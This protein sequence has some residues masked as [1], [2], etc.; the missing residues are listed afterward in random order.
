MVSYQPWSPLGWEGATRCQGPCP[1]CRASCTPPSSPCCWRWTTLHCWSIQ[2]QPPSPGIPALA[3]VKDPPHQPLEARWWPSWCA[4]AA[5]SRCRWVGGSRRGRRCARL[6]LKP[7]SIIFSS[8]FYNFTAKDNNWSM[9]LH[10]NPAA[11]RKAAGK[12]SKLE[13]ASMACRRKQSSW[14][15]NKGKG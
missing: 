7:A 14:R 5:R 15:K 2:G 11:N 6:F 12:L 8:T 4:W 1:W 13:A 10:W 9:P 3:L